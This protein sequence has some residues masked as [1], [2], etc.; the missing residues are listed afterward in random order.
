M[1]GSQNLDKLDNFWIELNEA[2]AMRPVAKAQIYSVKRKLT[3]KLSRSNV[4][5]PWSTWKNSSKKEKKKTKSSK[6]CKGI[7]TFVVL[8]VYQ[9][10]P[11]PYNPYL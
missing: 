7:E 8:D 11:V 2:T 10:F 6:K 1:L 5:R 4:R 9:V 3:S